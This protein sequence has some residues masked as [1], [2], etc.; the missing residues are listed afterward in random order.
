MNSSEFDPEIRGALKHNLIYNLMDGGFFG[1]AL[2]FASFVTV[3]PLFVS[4]MT[5]SPILIGLI[6]AIHSMG[7]QLP[8][9]LIADRVAR[10]SR[11]KPMVLLLTIQERIPFLGLHPRAP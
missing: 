11:Y 6:P 10:L 3:L 1:M 7:W 5:D 8:Q 4:N 9:L 2:G